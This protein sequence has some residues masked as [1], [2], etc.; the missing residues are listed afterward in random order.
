MLILIARVPIFFFHWSITDLQCCVSF[1]CREKWFSYTYITILFFLQILFPY[2]LLQ[3]IEYSSLC[4]TVGPCWKNSYFL[5]TTGPSTLQEQHLIMWRLPY[6][7]TGYAFLHWLWTIFFFL[8]QLIYYFASL[9]YLTNGWTIQ[10]L[11][12]ILFR[13]IIYISIWLKYCFQMKLKSLAGSNYP[14]TEI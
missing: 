9:E 4:R 2:R 7:N 11:A 10:S 12:I 6:P 8:K 5:I 1:R 13:N 14:N 3:N